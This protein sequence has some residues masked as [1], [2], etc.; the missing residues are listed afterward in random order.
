MGLFYD[1]DIMFIANRLL[2]VTATQ[3]E[4]WNVHQW[5]VRQ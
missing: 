1:A 4:L 2:D 5:D 3:S